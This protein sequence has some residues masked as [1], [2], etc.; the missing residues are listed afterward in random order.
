MERGKSFAGPWSLAAVLVAFVAVTLIYIWLA[1]PFEGPDE[2]EHFGYVTWLAQGHGFPPQ[3]DEAWSTP[4]RQEASQPPFYYSIAALLASLVDLEGPPAAFRPNPHFPSNA[5]GTVADNKNIA[6]HYPGDTSPLQGGWL[7]LYLARGV[8]LLMGMS[9]ILCVYGLGREL[10][11][12]RRWFA[13]AAAGLVAAMP[14][15]LFMSGL[16]SNDMTAAATGALTLWLL[17][18]LVRRGPSGRRGLALG[19]AYG[20]AILSKASSLVLLAPIGIALAWLW[21]RRE[22]PAGNALRAG[23]GAGAAALAVGGWWYIR[24]WVLYGSPLGLSTHYEAP[25]AVAAVGQRIRPAAAWREVFDS[26]WAAFGWGNIKFP[27][28]VYAIL[29]G[30]V[31]TAIIGLALEAWRWWRGDRKA[32]TR[33][34]LLALMALSVL[35]LGLALEAWMRQ[36][37]APHGRLLFP[38]LAAVA[39]LLVAGWQ[40]LHPRLVAACLAVVLLLA[41]LAPVTLIRPAYALPRL[42][43]VDPDANG[44]QDTTG[45]RF[46]EIA[47]L[48]E[49]RVGQRSVEAGEVLP[50]DVCWITRQAADKDYS[51]LVHLVGP[52]NQ[53]VAG[54]HTYP[55]LGSYP[56]SA[57]Q[58]GRR[59]C[60]TIRVDIPADLARTLAYQVEIG[61]LDSQSNRRLP[62]TGPDGQPIAAPFAASVRLAA[63]EPPQLPSIPAGDAAIR[64]VSAD[65]PE[66]WPAGETFD[67]DLRWWLAEPVEQDYS[68]FV[69]L[70]DGSGQVVAQGDGPPL[71]GWYP[72]SMWQAGDV[73]DDVHQVAAPAVDAAN[74]YEL[75]VGWYNLTSGARLGPEYPLGEVE[76][77]P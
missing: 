55:G 72:T 64:L 34:L 9:A 17:A 61:L 67:V 22:Y 25:W 63:A 18:R 35:G 43:E 44:V 24:S 50:V 56:T 46:G 74:R 42:D 71:A 53:V 68:V 30:L 60:D 48:A 7:A 13:L 41:L 31:L 21:W 40:A 51:V 58:P 59:F 33:P 66:T 69:H 20:L 19:A 15:T 73:V 11:P 4:I 16:V 52:D 39:V 62:V 49:V 70:R 47:E 3:G 6:I 1:P 8:S 10:Y 54:R 37:T 32:L 12:E 75:V 45:W 38:A 29:A 14:Q 77:R 36:V 2:P 76:V 26:F 5:P 28:W 57:W 23:A 65:F 27:W